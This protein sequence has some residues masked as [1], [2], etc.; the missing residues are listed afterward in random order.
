MLPAQEIPVSSSLYPHDLLPFEGTPEWIRVFLT[1]LVAL[2][3]MILLISKWF[4]C[5]P[6][7]FRPFRR[8]LNRWSRRSIQV[9][10]RVLAHLC[11]WIESILQRLFY[12]GDDDDLH[13][14]PSF[15]FTLYKTFRYLVACLVAYALSEVGRMI[16]LVIY[17]SFLTVFLYHQLTDAI[18]YLN[19]AVTLIGFV[20]PFFMFMV[21]N[22]ARVLCDYW[23]FYLRGDPMLR[24]Y[25]VPNPIYVQALIIRAHLDSFL[26]FFSQHPPLRGGIPLDN[27]V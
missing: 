7:A 23:D 3:Q 6:C 21:S 19:L 15:A 20:Y 8:F 12:W 17:L 13:S 5:L 18:F 9:F 16:L 10:L 11:L 27:P 26:G 4:C 1:F 24:V 2:F 14:P 25:T 22:S